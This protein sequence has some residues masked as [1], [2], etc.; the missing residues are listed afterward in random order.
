MKARKG[1]QCVHAGVASANTKGITTPIYAS[2]SFLFLHDEDQVVYPRYFNT[3]NQETVAAKIAALENGDQG[4]VLGSGMAAVVATLLSHLKQGDHVLFHSGIYGGTSDFASETLPNYGI[5]RSFVRGCDAASFQAELRDNTK[6]IFFESPTNPLLQIIDIEHVVELARPRGICT[7]VDNTFA[8]PI[9]QNP[10]KLGVDV[11]IHSGTKY[12]N[13]HSDVNCGAIVSSNERMELIRRVATQLGSTL[14]SRA[15]YLLERGLKT[16]AIRV[17]RQ[18][19]NAAKLAELLDQHARVRQV[20]FPGLP[21]H[22]GHGIAANQMARFGAMLS[23]EMDAGESQTKQMVSRLRVAY[24]AV[25]LG[26][27]ETLVCFPKDTSHAKISSSA[28]AAEGI[29]DSL[30]RVSVGIEEIEDLL[31]DFEQ[32]LQ[33]T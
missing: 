9:N 3:P 6:M 5:E 20:H 8:T 1:T 33:Q 12:L 26:G 10:L 14:D 4:L 29:T 30:V 15:C 25:S 13:G 17:E 16:L 28:R 2:T 11:V 18:C 32:A 31:A 19:D 22:P 24:P 23:F 27:V 21:E 7:V